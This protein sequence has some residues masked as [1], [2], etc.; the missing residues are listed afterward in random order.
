MLR[1]AVTCAMRRLATPSG[2]G[3]RAFA[4][5]DARWRAA[6]SSEGK[7]DEDGKAEGDL[8]SGVETA[9]DTAAE[10]TDSMDTSAES[11]EDDWE[12][13]STSEDPETDAGAVGDVPASSGLTGATFESIELSSKTPGGTDV[14]MVA[15]RPLVLADESLMEKE[16]WLYDMSEQGHTIHDNPNIR[17]AHLSDRTKTKMYMMHLKD[18]STWGVPQLAEQ[19]RVRQQRVMAILALKKIQQ[20]HLNAQK[21]TFPHLEAAWEE[22]HGSEDRGTGEKHVRIVPELPKFQVVHADTTQEELDLI[23]PK[24][25]S[26]E[27]RAEKEERVLVR[28]FKDALAYNMKETA[29]SLNRTGTYFP[30][31]THRLPARRDYHDC[32]LIRTGTCS[33]GNSYEVTNTGNSYQ[34]C[35]KLTQYCA[36]LPEVTPRYPV[37]S[38]IYP[39]RPTDTFL[40]IVPG[41]LRRPPSRPIGGWG[42]MVVPM[43][44]SNSKKTHAR[45]KREG[46]TVQPDAPFVAYPDGTKREINDDEKVM[47]AR[48]RNRPVRKTKL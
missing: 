35:G 3:V 21:Q 48:R 37:Q 47:F 6:F 31:T 8:P 4:G 33:Y 40:L 13:P 44:E 5:H 43:V 41:R 29:P 46:W 39:S 1:H 26:S 34:Y 17:N 19:Y 2:S 30:I 9:D 15:V 24:F 27:D 25:V 22:L 7:D 38:R 45:A 23:L 14:R 42:L 32:L 36:N 18:P 28:Q 12:L 10:A 20:V 11:G 16:G